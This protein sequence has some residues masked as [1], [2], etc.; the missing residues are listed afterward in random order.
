MGTERRHK[1]HF[2]SS[3]Q[4]HLFK[5]CLSTT[6]DAQFKDYK[7]PT[8]LVN[9]ITA[10]L[11]SLSPCL[12]PRSRWASCRVGQ[13]AATVP[14]RAPPGHINLSALVFS[15]FGT[16]NQRKEGKYLESHGHDS[17]SGNHTQQHHGDCPSTGNYRESVSEAPAL[18][19]SCP[20]LLLRLPS[21][22]TTEKSKRRSSPWASTR[23]ETSL[24][25][26]SAHKPKQQAVLG[27]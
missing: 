13:E 2:L 16:V 21:F 19:S 8:K 11:K 10:A 5:I 20:S 1:E 17:V 18:T 12:H 24:R 26:I 22:K 27:T 15:I 3:A 6:L 9:R 23:S 14:L 7:Q 25:E 4:E